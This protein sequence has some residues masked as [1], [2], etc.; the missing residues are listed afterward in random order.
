MARKKT[1]KEEYAGGFPPSMKAFETL[2]DPRNGPAKRH[3]CGE[4]LFIALA[5]MISGMDDSQDFERVAEGRKEWLTKWLKL[6]DGTPSDDTFP[7]IFTALD[8]EAC[9]GCFIAFTA[10][11][12]PR[13]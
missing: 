8:P 13:L 1:R 9:C 12:A 5:S 7:R 10:S 11:V 3:Q 2:P 6:P 4:L